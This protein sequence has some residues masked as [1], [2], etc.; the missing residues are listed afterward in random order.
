[1]FFQIDSNVVLVQGTGIALMIH[2]DPRFVDCYASPTVKALLIG[3][4]IS[5]TALDLVV[6]PV[7]SGKSF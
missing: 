7:A 3:V 1:M 4:M 5:A 2:R 6:L